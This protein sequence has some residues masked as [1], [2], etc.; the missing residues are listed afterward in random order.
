[1]IGIEESLNQK[2]RE[3]RISFRKKWLW[4]VGMVLIASRLFAQGKVVPPPKTEAEIKEMMKI[5]YN[6]HIMPE[7]ADPKTLEH[8]LEVGQVLIFYDHPLMVPWLSVGGILINAPVEQVFA[9]VSD[10]THY[11]DFVP[12]THSAEVEK[13][14]ENFKRVSFHLKVDMFFLR[15]GVDYGVYHYDRPPYRTDWSFAW[16]EF[17]RNIGFWELIPSSDGK[18]TMAFYSNYSEPRSALLKKIYAQDPLL[19][20]TTN[21][22]ASIMVTRAVKA[23]TEKRF[24]ASGG[25]LPPVV[26]PRPV[27]D[28]LAEDPATMD[29]FLQKGRLL[30][31]EDGPTVYV[32]AGALVD[33][34]QN[35]AWM[36]VTDFLRYPEF[37]PGTKKVEYL[38]AGRNGPMYHWEVVTN[39]GFLEY[40]YNYDA[41]FVLT[42]Q[43]SVRW[44]SKG[45]MSAGARGF[46]KFIPAGS[47]TLVFT[48]TTAD[49]RAMGRIPR[50]ALSKQPTL[51]HGIMASQSL[52]NINAL[53]KRIEK[54]AKTC[55]G[56]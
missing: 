39:L 23:E 1:L 9:V 41:E 32:T 30:V 42:P 19:E 47:R 36:T 13:F 3:M 7:G 27:F 45:E 44:N 11:K 43:E 52:L 18:R 40:A 33:A 5:T 6:Q 55:Q 12:F 34:P 54:N 56:N 37:A 2:G 38:G 25:V 17:D 35:K 29:R 49:L 15:Y 48:G 31:L 53:K 14:A 24:K 10:F 22:S 46:W 21:I 26:K 50:Y 8:L 16:G 28:V 4:L 51:E 20:I